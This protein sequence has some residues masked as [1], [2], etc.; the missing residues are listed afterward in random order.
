MTILSEPLKYGWVLTDPEALTF[1]HPNAGTA[2]PFETEDA[3]VAWYRRHVLGIVPPRITPSGGTAYGFLPEGEC[4]YCDLLVEGG[5]WGPRHD[6]RHGKHC[7]CD[8]CF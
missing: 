3:A 4:S 8:Y 7:T 6:T 1:S 2:G 5:G